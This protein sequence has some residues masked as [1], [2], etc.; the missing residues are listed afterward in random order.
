M[1]RAG[2]DITIRELA[3]LTGVDKATVSHI[4]K[5]RH[6]EGGKRAP[7]LKKVREWLEHWVIFVAPSEGD[8]CGGVLLK[9]GV[10][11]GSYREGKPQPSIEPIGDG[12]RQILEYWRAHPDEWKALTEEARSATLTAIFGVAPE[13]DPILADAVSG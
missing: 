8:H 3:Q 5:E 9:P 6:T 1:A 12:E 2:L 10:T 7:T 13:E 4:E 11:A